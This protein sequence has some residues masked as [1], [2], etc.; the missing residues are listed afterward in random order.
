MS[1]QLR[2]WEKCSTNVFKLVNYL[3][4]KVDF[5]CHTWNFDSIPRP[6]IVSIGKEDTVLHSKETITKML[7]TYKPVSYCIEDQEKNKKVLEDT[8]NKGLEVQNKKPP[9]AWSSPQFYGI[10]AASNLKGEYELQHNFKYDACIRLRYDQYIPESQI[11]YIIDILN[12]I[13]SNTIYTMHNREHDGYPKML[14]GDVF[15][16]ADSPTYDKVSKF[17]KAIPTINT[18]LFTEGTPPENVLTH[19][20][21]HLDIKNFRTYLDIKICL[22][23]RHVNEKLRL[24]LDG[25]G[26]HEVIYENIIN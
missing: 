20:I 4:H 2:T 10:M 17:Y 8:V 7:D 1:G 12:Q 18:E 25:T 3:G 21:N 5:F 14:Y 9:S 22:F 13:E 26:P 11:D 15:W 6:I 24:G 19:Y 16:I 23:K